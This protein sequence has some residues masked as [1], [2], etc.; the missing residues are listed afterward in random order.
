MRSTKTKGHGKQKLNNPRH[1]NLEPDEISATINTSGVFAVLPFLDFKFVTKSTVKINTD[2]KT[3][4]MHIRSTFSTAL[5]RTSHRTPS[6]LWTTVTGR[7]HT[8]SVME[9]SHSEISYS[10]SYVEQSQGDITL[11]QLCR[12]V[13]VR[14]KKCT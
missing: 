13:T 6:Q 11:F 3:V 4:P 1:K 12:P 10:I 2:D 7:Y 8:V 5:T 9:T 14:Y